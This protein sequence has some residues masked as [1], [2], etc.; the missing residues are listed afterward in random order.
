MSIETVPLV[1]NLPRTAL[2]P[3]ERLVL[4]AYAAYADPANG[5]AFPSLA[6]VVEMTSLSK[7]GVIKVR[8][9]L[10]EKGYLVRHTTGGGRANTSLFSLDMERLRGNPEALLIKGRA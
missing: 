5:R 6:A 8:E 3:F 7:K 2:D 9:R 10:I 1:L 4:S